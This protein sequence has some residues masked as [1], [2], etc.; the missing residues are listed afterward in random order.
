V[1]SGIK[2]AVFLYH[3]SSGCL[4]V[5]FGIST[6]R[7]STTN[8]LN[9][10]FEYKESAETSVVFLHFLILFSEFFEN[11]LA[12]RIILQDPKN[13][14]GRDNDV[15]ESMRIWVINARR[16]AGGAI[17]IKSYQLAFCVYHGTSAVARRCFGICGETCHRKSILAILEKLAEL[18]RDLI[19]YRL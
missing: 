3:I 2:N 4:R 14:V 10:E 18:I 16:A 5:S 9:S 19:I 1:S 15:S 6:F 17:E 11:I 12:R 8:E 7:I 13:I